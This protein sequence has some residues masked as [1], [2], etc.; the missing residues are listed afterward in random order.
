M[1]AADLAPIIQILVNQYNVLMLLFLGVLGLLLVCIVR[2]V[3]VIYR[4]VKGRMDHV[5]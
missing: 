3:I 4:S 1:T 5:R 2:L